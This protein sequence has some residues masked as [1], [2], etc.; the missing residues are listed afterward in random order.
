MATEDFVPVAADDW[1]Q[2]RRQDAEGEFFR[3]VADQGP[4]K[5]EG[6]GTRQGIY[7]FTADGKLLAY[8][9][10]GQNAGGRRATNSSG[11]WRSSRKLPSRPPRAG[12]ASRWATAGK[13]D[14]RYTRTPPPG[15][16]IV[17]VYTRILDRDGD[18]CPARGRAR[19]T[20]GD[21]AARDHLWLTADEVRSPGPAE[22]RAGRTY[23]VP[24]A[25]ADR[26]VRFHLVDNTRGEPPFWRRDQVRRAKLT[27]TV[28]EVT[29]DGIELR[30]DG[31]A[32]LATGRRSRQGRPRVRRPAARRVP[33][34]PGEADHRPVRRGGGRATT[35]ATRP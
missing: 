2:R 20:G 34:P 18:E 3:K 21:A 15:G 10:A 23:D 35:G 6:G 7:C 32:L 11:H 4:R 9:N 22:G 26:I 28:E 16:L 31:A 14:P 5:G 19:R 24:T 25:V 30:L 29:A 13:P 33:V 8:K 17:S 1:Y 12:R 27:L